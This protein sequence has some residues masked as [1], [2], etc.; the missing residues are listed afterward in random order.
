MTSGSDIEGY[1]ISEYLGLVSGQTALT[2]KVF[3]E[4][5]GNSEMDA[6]ESKE[7]TKKFDA[8]F[9]LQHKHYTTI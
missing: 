8:E 6:K 4:F 7:L 3:V 1:E 2:G 9:L 5:S